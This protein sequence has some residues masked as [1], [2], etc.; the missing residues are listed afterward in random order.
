MCTDSG[1]IDFCNLCY[2]FGH[3]DTQCGFRRSHVVGKTSN[4]CR[5]GD[6]NGQNYVK[7][8]K[9]DYNRSH[10]GAG[11]RAQCD[12]SANNRGVR[13]FSGYSSGNSSVEC[14]IR[15]S[16][17]GSMCINK[18]VMWKFA[19]GGTFNENLVIS[20]KYKKSFVQLSCLNED[21]QDAIYGFESNQ[22]DYLSIFGAYK[23]VFDLK[24]KNGYYKKTCVVLPLKIQMGNWC[25][26]HYFVVV[27]GI[28]EDKMVLGR[29]F[30]EEFNVLYDKSKGKIHLEAGTQELIHVKQTKTNVSSA[31]MVPEVDYLLNF[32]NDLANLD[33]FGDIYSH[34]NNRE[35][36]NYEKFVVYRPS[37]EVVRD[38]KLSNVNGDILT[39]EKQIESP[40]SPCLVEENGGKSVAIC[41]NSCA[42]VNQAVIVRAKREVD[43]CGKPGR[44]KFGSRETDGNL[45]C[46]F[47][48][49]GYSLITN[50]LFVDGNIFCQC[51]ELNLWKYVKYNTFT[52]LQVM[53]SINLIENYNFKI[54]NY[55]L[56]AS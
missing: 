38:D 24:G 46:A 40:I 11:Y 3:K 9:C 28:Y 18:R 31:K 35:H 51:D 29:D 27:N 12:L 42:S 47:Q 32:D 34:G 13:N 49:G 2:V 56:I 52:L 23:E 48:G 16:Y 55:N 15:S 50:A 26:I 37:V 54:K 39:S 14:N 5:R 41:E 10:G 33:I 6:L 21:L 1:Q 7:S 43:N 36:G 19:N 25:D 44:A 17:S 22:F 30:I 20:S 45:I 8:G 4:F 53:K